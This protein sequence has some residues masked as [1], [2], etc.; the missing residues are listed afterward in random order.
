M[1]GEEGQEESILVIR[2]DS[3][4]D[5]RGLT[6]PKRSEHYRGKSASKWVNREGTLNVG[7]ADQQ[8]KLYSQIKD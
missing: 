6:E 3:H 5:L 8:P 2:C 1:E 7:V 4:P